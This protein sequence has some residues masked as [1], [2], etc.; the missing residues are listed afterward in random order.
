[1]SF[2]N[3]DPEEINSSFARLLEKIE[4]SNGRLEGRDREVVALFPEYR[5]DREDACCC[6]DAAI[7]R[8]LSKFWK[9]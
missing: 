9:H 3:M 6:S 7:A 5:V 2:E 4:Q 8:T 1:M